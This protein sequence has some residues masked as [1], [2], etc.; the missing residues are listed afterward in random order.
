MQKI[1]YYGRVLL[2]LARCSL[3]TQLE[4][5]FNYLT[6]LLIEIAYALVKLIYVVMVYQTGCRIG[7]LTPDHIAMFVGS[8]ALLTGIYM[9]YYRGYTAIPDYVKTGDLDMLLTKPLSLRFLVTFRKLDYAMP[10][11]NAAVGIALIAYGWQKI[12]LPVTVG[13]IAGFAGFILLSTATTLF[14]FLIP[15]ILAFWFVGVNGVVSLSADLWDFG[16]MPGQLYGKVIDG[17]GTFVF[18]IFLI[19]N[20][21]VWFVLGELRPAMLA[22]A[23]AAPVLAF[24]LSQYAWKLALKHYTS[25]S[26]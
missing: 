7:T 4:Y 19:T 25:A 24:L 16:N 10:L 26:S 5:R 13:A 15:H 12:G 20:Y 3:M 22:W 21:P 9:A 6:S 1:R 14:F 18:P 17:L 2:A 11:P 8:Y 23:I